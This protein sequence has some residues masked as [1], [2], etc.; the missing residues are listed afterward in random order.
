M[1][2]E[3]MRK[4][5]GLTESKIQVNEKFNVNSD[6]DINLRLTGNI[7]YIDISH[8]L[9]SLYVPV[10]DSLTRMGQGFEKEIKRLVQLIKLSLAKYDVELVTYYSHIELYTP[11]NKLQSQLKVEIVSKDRDLIRE[12]FDFVQSELKG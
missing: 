2:I 9:R 8:K 7:I 3:Q 12:I 6:L 1:N 5:A 4:L 10:D 11:D